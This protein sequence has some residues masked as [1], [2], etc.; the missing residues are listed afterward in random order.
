MK[1][2]NTLNKTFERLKLPGEY[3][4]THQY[5]PLTMTPTGPLKERIEMIESEF[6]VFFSGVRLLDVACNWGFFSLSY[7]RNFDEVVGVDVNKECIDFCN[8]KNRFAHVSFIHSSFRDYTSPFGFDKIFVGNVAHHLFMD[9]KDWS[10]IAKLHALCDGEVL[11]EG[12]LTTECKDI[13]DL[14][15]QELHGEF[16]RFR[17]EMEK[18]FTLTKIV[19]TTDYTP[20]RYLMLW[21]KKKPRHYQLRE[22]PIKKV[23]SVQ[24]FKVYESEHNLIVKVFMR[25]PNAQ[26]IW[27]GLIRVRLAC[28][29]PITN[30]LVGEVYIADTLVG[31]VEEK[32]EGRTYNYFENETELWNKI[33]DHEIFL[34][35]NGYID[36]DTATINFNKKTGLLFDKS[37]VFPINKL[38]N[39]SIDVIPVLYKQSY[40]SQTK[41][42]DDIMAA[43][44]SRDSKVIEQTFR[45]AKIN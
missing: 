5:N 35:K 18:Y 30:G 29:S 13:Y 41:Y 16:N 2:I 3:P 1:V 22:L 40:A 20:D 25:K 15:P 14:V 17:Q 7:A 4:P 12:A 36:L 23:I 38:E 44:K 27:N 37:C 42:L 8:L 10:W 6:P 24:D 45:V 31:W 34:A 43:I 28:N 21:R 32:L 9:T 33:C 11:I 39:S 26:Q 19:K